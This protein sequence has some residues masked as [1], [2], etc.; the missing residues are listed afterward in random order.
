MFLDMHVYVYTNIYMYMLYACIAHSHTYSHVCIFV[1]AHI[2]VRVCLYGKSRTESEQVHG[3]GGLRGEGS[4]AG[5]EDVRDFTF[6]FN[7]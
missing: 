3:G 5:K 4:G 2:C 1:S 7:M 6:I